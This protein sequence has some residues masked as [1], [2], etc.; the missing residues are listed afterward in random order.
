V[1]LAA[2]LCGSSAVVGLVFGLSFADFIGFLFW[3]IFV[4]TIGSGC[5][6]GTVLWW[7][8]NKF[9]RTVLFPSLAA[10]PAWQLITASVV[11]KHV[12]VLLGVWVASFMIWHLQC[13]GW[14]SAR[15][16]GCWE[17]W[18]LGDGFGGGGGGSMHGVG[19]RILPITRLTPNRTDLMPQGAGACL[20]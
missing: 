4:D 8:C 12:L 20:D 13:L 1:L 11:L 18:T 9:L 10:S 6:I 7:I 15:F 2:F 3:V 19:W 14:I 16:S 5:V 17:R